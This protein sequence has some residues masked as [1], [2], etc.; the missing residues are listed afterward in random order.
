M[1]ARIERRVAA[2]GRVHRQRTGN[3]CGHEY[4]FCR[5]QCRQRQGRA[6]LC[7]VQE[8]QTFLRRQRERDEAGVPQRRRG[9]HDIAIAA[10]FSFADQAGRQMRQGCQI[11]GG[12]HRSF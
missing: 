12:A 11:A 4:R 1:D 7:A 9:G 3:R 5:E 2:L 6:D 8:R 10:G